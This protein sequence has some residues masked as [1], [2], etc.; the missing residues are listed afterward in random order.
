MKAQYYT[1]SYGGFLSKQ[2][3]YK[4]KETEVLHNTKKTENKDQH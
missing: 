3:M 2:N 1:T 4:F